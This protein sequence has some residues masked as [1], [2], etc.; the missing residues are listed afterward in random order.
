MLPSHYNHSIIVA[1]SAA[2]GY[3]DGSSSSYRCQERFLHTHAGYRTKY[4]VRVNLMMSIA[5]TAA[6]TRVVG[7]L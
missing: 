7:L 4:D 1:K 2:E 6:T 5:L 3:L